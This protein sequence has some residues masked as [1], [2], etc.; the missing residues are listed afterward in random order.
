ML[1]AIIFDFDGVICES[2]EVKT[3]AF[4]R[5]F[6]GYPRQLKAIVHYHERNGGVSRFKKFAYIYKYILKQRLTADQSRILGEQFT[7]YSFQAVIRSKYVKGALPFLKKHHKALKLFVVSGTPED[8]MRLV[9]RKRRL[10]R[11]FKAVYGSPRTKSRLIRLILKK[12]SLKKQEVVF[13]GDSLTDLKAAK[14]AGIAFVGRVRG[15]Q[16]NYFTDS[17][18]IISDFKDL[19]RFLLINAQAHRA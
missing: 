11:F 12:N 15:G 9:V 19:E 3:Q 16:R 2:V 13:V 8:E 4:R 7:Q 14:A 18:C 5:L 1:K 6:R 17:E 10:N